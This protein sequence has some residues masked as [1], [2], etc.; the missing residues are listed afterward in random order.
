MIYV[1]ANAYWMRKKADRLTCVA[2]GK[3][4][5]CTIYNERPQTC[6]DFEVGESRCI[7]IQAEQKK[8]YQYA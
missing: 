4:G 3:D 7:K 1:R 5:H 2:L 8:R 6:K